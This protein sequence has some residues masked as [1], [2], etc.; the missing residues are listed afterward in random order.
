M[1]AYSNKAFW[2]GTLDR[3]IATFGQSLLAVFTA[4]ATGI[5]EIDPAQLFSVAGLAVL[6]SVATSIAYPTRVTD[7][8]VFTESTV[9]K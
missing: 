9:A 2:L 8:D 6:A 1:S 7:G 5:L 3:A 4:G